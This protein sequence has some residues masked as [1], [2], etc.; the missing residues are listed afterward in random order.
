MTKVV[1]KLESV[2]TKNGNQKYIEE[3][4]K[5]KDKATRKRDSKLECKYL[6]ILRDLYFRESH[7]ECIATSDEIILKSMNDEDI[8]ASFDRLARSLIENGDLYRAIEV[9]TRYIS[10]SKASNNGQELY[11]AHEI[12]G[13]VYLEKSGSDIS[14]NQ[15]LNLAKKSFTSAAKILSSEEVFSIR[16]RQQRQPSLF[17]NMAIVYKD[18]GNM[19]NAFKYLEEAMSMTENKDWDIYSLALLNMIYTL[20]DC[21]QYEEAL[22]NIRLYKT[23]FDS[24]KR[25]EN[26]VDTFDME[27]S[28]YCKLNQFEN[29]KGL[30]ELRIDTINETSDSELNQ[31]YE[32]YFANRTNCL[33]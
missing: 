28:L 13:L 25:S 2:T 6:V 29:A 22:A 21:K 4:L 5:L 3:L 30:L 1:Y 27:Y 9:V 11:N 17:I 12:L 19:E 14:N 26:M 33:V 8:L 20:Q 23:I 32:V 16:E 24:N 7:D 31:I 15:D 18:Q 10:K